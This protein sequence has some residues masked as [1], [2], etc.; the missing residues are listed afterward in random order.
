[1]F[2]RR[3]FLSLSLLLL[4]G[5]PLA[6][7]SS[8]VYIGTYTVRAGG[9]TKD[10]T[11]KGIYVARFDH[12]SGKLS[13][14]ELAA[15]TTNPSFV[16]I[17]PNGRYL[18]AVGEMYGAGG[19]PGGTVTAFSIDATTGKLTQLNQVSSEGGGPC[20]VTIDKTGKWALVA[21]YGT[22]S[23]ASIAVGPDGKL[24]AA[25]SVIQHKGSGTDPARQKGPHAHSINLDARNRFAIA[26]D[27]GLDRLFIYKFDARSGKL[28]QHAEFHTKPG[29]GPAT[30]VSTPP[31]SSLSSSTKWP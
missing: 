31:A 20:F 13:T 26:A 15:E 16:A 14:P 2:P 22:G 25:A 4:A 5:L 6:A 24:G 7:Q 8:L 21:N 19:R 10:P 29:S 11:S 18:Y 1:M 9:A 28:S 27:L 17:H 30:S 3:A 23:V 12:A